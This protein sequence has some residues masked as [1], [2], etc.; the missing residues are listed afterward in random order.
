MIRFTRTDN[1]ETPYH[2][3]NNIEIPLNDIFLYF[4]CQYEPEEQNI[5]DIPRPQNTNIPEVSTTSTMSEAEPLKI[6]LVSCEKEFSKIAVKINGQLC[7]HTLTPDLQYYLGV[8]TNA[9][10]NVNSNDI[11]TCSKQGNRYQI[12]FTEQL[13]KYIYCFK[14]SILIA[15]KWLYDIYKVE[16]SKSD[17]IRIMFDYYDIKQLDDDRYIVY[18]R[19]NTYSGKISGKPYSD[20]VPDYKHQFIACINYRNK[21]T[22]IQSSH[23]VKIKYQISKNGNGYCML[24]PEQ[25]RTYNDINPPP[26]PDELIKLGFKHVE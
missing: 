21:P 11:F 23:I 17:E 12:K 20:V 4:L 2:I 22:W 9:Y 24:S 15:Q 13:P 19:I 6:E 1:T 8:I 18:I 5:Q 26:N 14:E 10:N 3:P 25:G 16:M 7:T